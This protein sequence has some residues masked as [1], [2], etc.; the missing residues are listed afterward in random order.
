MFGV[1][2][3]ET[4]KLEGVPLSTFSEAHAAV[5]IFAVR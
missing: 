2:F 3:I 1:Q 4:E 5:D